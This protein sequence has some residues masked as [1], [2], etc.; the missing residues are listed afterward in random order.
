MSVVQLRVS[1]LRLDYA[2]QLD[3]YVAGVDEL[4]R[5]VLCAPTVRILLCARRN[6]RIFRQARLP[7]DSLP[8]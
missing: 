7:A 3:F 1:R 8:G 6:E 4:R 2:G 5:P